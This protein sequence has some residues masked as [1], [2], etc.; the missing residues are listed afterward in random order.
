LKR[1]RFS[2]RRRKRPRLAVELVFVGWLAFLYDQLLGASP[3]RVRLAVAHGAVL[4]AFE[5]QLGIAFELSLNRLLASQRLLATIASYYYD[6]AH[7]VVTFGLLALLWWR[8]PDR[9]PALRT[10]LVG[11]NLLAFVVFAFYPMA[12]P[13][14]LAGSHFI[15]IVADSGTVGQWHS[16]ALARSADQYA[17]MPSLHVAWAVWSTL[18][19]FAL[20][21]RRSLRLLA[22]VYP[23]LTAVDVIATANH[24]LLDGLAG[25]AS[26]GL[27]VSAQKAARAVAGVGWAG[28]GGRE[29]PAVCGGGT[30]YAGAARAYA[31]A[32]MARA[33]GPLDAEM[34]GQSLVTADSSNAEPRPA[35]G[36]GLWR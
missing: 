10:T 16:G 35:R 11:V 18:A 27:V 29:V 8:R 14:L 17:A 32:T 7:F 2:S 21:R 1:L 9:Y 34:F 28:R 31:S 12:P 22:L 33:P 6:N 19:V 26:V 24:L 36:G 13:R 30:R 3:P 5:R 20:T 15:D 25:A 4:L 23:L